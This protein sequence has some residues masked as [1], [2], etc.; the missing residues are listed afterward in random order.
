MTNFEIAL[1]H[2]LKVAGFVAL[3]AFL[4]GI[5]A[6]VKNDP[7]LFFYTPV[8]NIVVAFAWKWLGLPNDPP[9]GQE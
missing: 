6:V 1:L 5:V 3:A 2:A 7:T 9:A 4:T 8:V